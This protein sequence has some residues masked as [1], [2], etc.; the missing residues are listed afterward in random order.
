MTS[1]L[2]DRRDKIHNAC[3]ACRFPLAAGLCC[4]WDG[5][6]PSGERERSTGEL[7]TEKVSAKGIILQPDDRIRFIM[8]S[9]KGFSFVRGKISSHQNNKNG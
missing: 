5:A 9:V 4:Q 6:A 8:S 7:G 2:S 3:S 1:I